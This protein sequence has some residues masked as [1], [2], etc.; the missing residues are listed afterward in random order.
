MDDLRN[1]LGSF[2][3]DEPV[4]RC[5]AIWVCSGLRSS[6]A[7]QVQREGQR[8]NLGTHPMR[9]KRANAAAPGSAKDQGDST[10]LI[11]GG[12]GGSVSMPAAIFL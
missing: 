9:V 10:G 8:K 5:L 11:C 12:F 2:G 3:E 6:D 7:W 1:T 4:A